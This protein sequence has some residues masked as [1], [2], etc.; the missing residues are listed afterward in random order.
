MSVAVTGVRIKA[1]A[2]VKHPEWV[3][4]DAHGNPVLDSDGNPVP[5]EQP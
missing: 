3:A 5:K 4:L 2:S 1:A